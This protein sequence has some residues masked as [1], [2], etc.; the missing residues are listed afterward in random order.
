MK[1]HGFLMYD[2]NNWLSLPWTC[3]SASMSSCVRPSVSVGTCSRSSWCSNSSD[4]VTLSDS[5]HTKIYIQSSTCSIFASI[6][7]LNN[8][9][10]ISLDVENFRDLN[11]V[12]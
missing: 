7:N 11:S 1:I 3:F 12:W 2:N 8:P 4:T 6:R 9:I 10:L 5:R